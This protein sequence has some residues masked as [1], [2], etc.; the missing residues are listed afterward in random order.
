MIQLAADVPLSSLGRSSKDEYCSGPH[1][2]VDR[3]SALTVNNHFTFISTS[4][5]KLLL[6]F[7]RTCCHSGLHGR[8]RRRGRL[9]Y[10]DLGGDEERPAVFPLIVCRKVT[11]VLQWNVSAPS[12]QVTS[13]CVTCVNRRNVQK[14]WKELRRSG[15][16]RVAAPEGL[17]VFGC[18]Q[19]QFGTETLSWLSQVL[20]RAS[21]VMTCLVQMWGRRRTD[22][23]MW[24]VT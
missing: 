10:K 4:L 13:R 21:L 9:W 3:S 20:L 6:Y 5:S 24:L 7:S 1:L 14:R 19:F 15:C 11:S 17:L 18:C 23:W 2:T 16:A 22:L 8:F 12:Q